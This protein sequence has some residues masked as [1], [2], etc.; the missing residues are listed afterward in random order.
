MNE[1][2][3]ELIHSYQEKEILLRVVRSPYY[4]KKLSRSETQKRLGQYKNLE[5]ELDELQKLIE[6]EFYGGESE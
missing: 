5:K 1:R 4:D 6:E 3:K 2:L